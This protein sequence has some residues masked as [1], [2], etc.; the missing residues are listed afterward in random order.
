MRVSGGRARGI[1]LRVPRGARFRPAIDRLR[2]GVFS[3][4]GARVE[5]SRFLDLF[6]GTGSYGLEALS[7]GATDGVF[8]E[9]DSEAVAALR[10]NL[11]AVCNSMGCNASVA[12]VS[13][14]D[15]FSWQPTGG[16]LFGLVFADP[17]FDDI[18][19]NGEA[20]F[21]HVTQ[22]LRPNPAGLFVF[23]MPGECDVCSAGWKL[24]RRI[25]KGH[26]QPTCGIFKQVSVEA[27]SGG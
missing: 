27:G 26:G 18:A 23:Q 9:R 15:V 19:A 13:A 1:P 22:I 24:D 6:A 11:A 7:R 14:S 10:S 20:I 16:E 2:Q 5:G 21:R 4:L 8:V 3:S 17:P 12:R 25:G